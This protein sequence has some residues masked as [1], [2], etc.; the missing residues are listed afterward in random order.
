MNLRNADTGPLRS[1]KLQP[2][3]FAFPA[4]GNNISPIL[5]ITSR[6]APK[7]IVQVKRAPTNQKWINELAQFQS[8]IFKRRPE[9]NQSR[10]SPLTPRCPLLVTAV[11]KVFLSKGRLKKC[12]ALSSSRDKQ[13]HLTRVDLQRLAAPVS[14]FRCASDDALY[15]G[16]IGLYW[17]TVAS[18]IPKRVAELDQQTERQSHPQQKSNSIQARIYFQTLLSS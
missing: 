7:H 16:L 8:D 15:A 17:I 1:C 14:L 18:R 4:G 2:N 11:N 3:S 10:L 6:A 5:A 13:T 9:H 12:A